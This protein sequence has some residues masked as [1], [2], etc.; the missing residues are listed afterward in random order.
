LQALEFLTSQRAREISDQTPAG[1]VHGDV[2]VLR[3]VFY[4]RREYG[5]GEPLFTRTNRIER[6][7]QEGIAEH[8]LAHLLFIFP[9][10]AKWTQEY[11][12]RIRQFRSM[13]STICF[14]LIPHCEV[15]RIQSLR[16]AQIY[17]P[18]AL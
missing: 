8:E 16:F 11:L 4:V 9:T 14:S 5:I 6:R 3:L 1:L 10:R 17:Q 13:P 18:K 2:D 7:A 12:F 15:H